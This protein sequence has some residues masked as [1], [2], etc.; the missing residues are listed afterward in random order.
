[1]GDF[2]FDA[3]FWP[4]PKAMVDE[5]HEMGIKLMVSVWPQIDLESE[6]YD[7]MRAHNYLAHVT[8]GKDVGMWWA[9]RQPVPR[10]HEPR[11]ARL[12]VGA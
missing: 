12:R 1:M 4:D 6:N 11:G 10:R 2:R 8:S 5:L 9:A 7:E 3:E